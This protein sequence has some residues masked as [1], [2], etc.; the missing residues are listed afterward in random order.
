MG[1]LGIIS[2]IFS[3]AFSV[4]PLNEG[5]QEWLDQRDHDAEVSQHGFDQ[6]YNQ[7]VNDVLHADQHN[8][9]PA[10]VT[11]LD[12]ALSGNPA[13]DAMDDSFSE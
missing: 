8:P 7:G 4:T 3:M 1:K 5:E 2:D 12:E 9:E 10:A 13:I 6:G 11:A